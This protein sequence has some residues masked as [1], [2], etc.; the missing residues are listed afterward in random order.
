VGSRTRIDGRDEEQTMKPLDMVDG[1]IW[2]PQCG[3]PSDLEP[4]DT[5]TCPK[6]QY[7]WRLRTAMELVE[8]LRS[9]AHMLTGASWEVTANQAM[10]REAADMI[11]R[12]SDALAQ[13]VQL[14]AHYAELLNMHDGG[15]RM[16]FPT[17]EVWLARLAELRKA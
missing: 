10:M 1:R 12:L 11:D 17:V 8:S 14:Q 6:C 7:H 3:T 13:S 9:R 16:I 4:D 5:W 2:C 15:Q